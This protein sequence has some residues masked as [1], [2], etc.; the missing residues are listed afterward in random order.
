MT[1]Y[2]FNWFYYLCRR[3]MCKKRPKEE[4]TIHIL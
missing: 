4:D 3:F 1:Q 2:I